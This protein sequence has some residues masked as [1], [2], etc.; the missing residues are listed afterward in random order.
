[1]TGFSA[2][3][4]G[5]FTVVVY[6]QSGG[7]AQGGPYHLD[8]TLAPGANAGGAL[9]SGVPVSGTLAEGALD[10]Y[11]LAAQ[12]GQAVTLSVTDI[13]ASA[14]VPSLTVYGPTGTVIVSTSGATVANSAFSATA[15][16][17]FTVIVY[18]S[19]GGNAQGGP[20]TI[21]ATLQ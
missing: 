11:T 10:S 12:A 21:S 8:Y 1:V 18:D 9:T 6:D 7:D 15:S 4:T 13:A 5:T 2:P 17:T 19:S 16:A 20:Y 3:S 14:F